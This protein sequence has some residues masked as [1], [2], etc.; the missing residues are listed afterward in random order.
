MTPRGPKW[1]G[2][3]KDGEPATQPQASA[4]GELR[5]RTQAF[6]PAE[7]ALHRAKQRT[8]SDAKTPVAAAGAQSAKGQTRPQVVQKPRLAQGVGSQGL[9]FQKWG[10]EPQNCALSLSLSPEHLL[11]S[12]VGLIPHLPG[13]QP[14]SPGLHP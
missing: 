13:G 12:T 6:H 14:P 8:M 4:P 2:C 10:S 1:S 3:P 9:G 5:T 11:L 7:E